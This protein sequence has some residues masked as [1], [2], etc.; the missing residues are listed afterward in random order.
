MLTEFSKEARAG[1]VP[2]DKWVITR[3]L[4]KSPKDYPD[5]KGQPHLQVALRMLAAGKPVN[6]GD[7]IPYVICCE[8]AAPATGGSPGQATDGAAASSTASASIATRSYHPDEVKKSN[9]ALKPDI[10]WYLVQ[11]VRCGVCA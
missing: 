11:Q 6:V 5:A 9:G 3:G 4:N 10:E 2:V 1:H 8:S 7:H